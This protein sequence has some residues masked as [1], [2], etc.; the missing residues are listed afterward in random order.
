MMI[1]DVRFLYDTSSSHEGIVQRICFCLKFGSYLKLWLRPDLDKVGQRGETLKCSFGPRGGPRPPNEGESRFARCLWLPHS[2][3]RD[4]SSFWRGDALRFMEGKRPSQFERCADTPQELACFTHDFATRN[5]NPCLRQS[6]QQ[7]RPCVP[8][9]M[10]YHKIRQRALKH[11][12]R[13][14]VTIR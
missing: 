11:A 8:R 5:R 12:S 6:W 7:A 14:H 10:D 2:L 1:L 4:Y 9:E 3:E 13:E